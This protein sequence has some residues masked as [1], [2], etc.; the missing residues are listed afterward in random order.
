L[1][2]AGLSI[3]VEF[4][5][6]SPTAG[7]CLQGICRFDQMY[8]KVDAEGAGRSNLEALLQ[9]DSSNPSAWC[10]YAELLARNGDIEGA[11]RA[12]AQAVT[13]G[14]SMAP[15]L[16][17]AVNFDF[18]HSRDHG[19]IDDARALSKRILAETGAFD[20]VIFSYLSH[21]GT[22]LPE[23]LEA[24]LPAQPRAAE[25]WL[26]WLKDN[27]ADRDLLDTWQWSQ[28]HRLDSQ[29]F[30][31]EFTWALWQRGSFAESRRL[32]AAW[33]DPSDDSSDPQRLLNGRFEAE[34][35]TSPF[36]WSL[37][38]L[39]SVAVTRDREG[40]SVR[41]LGTANAAFSGVHQFA[42]VGAGRYRFAA[43]IAAQ[44]LTSDRL[45]V[46]H[47]V[48]VAPQRKV[49]VQTQPVPANA[50][51]SRITLDFDVPPDV[52]AVEIALERIPSAKLDNKIAGTL[53]VYQVS[54]TRESRP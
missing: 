10:T 12:F 50:G 19:R 16:M 37:E 8:S 13:L 15:V 24:S 5:K 45:P 1:A 6:P 36:D 46:F 33:V 35:T 18:G 40:L 30:A 25:A 51:R 29:A 27:G 48:D 39:P 43:E 22:P 52:P 14:P 20:E 32:W 42:T 21:S 11:Q 53:R 2:V 9:E 7:V 26:A 3:L 17:R 54:L 23:V 47:I 4:A 34:P 31:L 41:F 38:G 28:A 44:D 49:D